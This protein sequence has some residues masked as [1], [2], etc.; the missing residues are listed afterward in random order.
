MEVVATEGAPVL[1]LSGSVAER[2]REL[3]AEP[4]ISLTHTDTMAGAVAI[5]QRP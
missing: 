4:V 1:R 5:L 2:A 3:Q